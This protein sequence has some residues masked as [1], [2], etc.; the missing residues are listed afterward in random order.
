MEKAGV[1]VQLNTEATPELV[2]AENP[3]AVFLASGGKP[4]V[5]PL[6][7]IEGK[8]SYLPMMSSVVR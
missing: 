8:M 4:I 5:A 2:K 3:E 6:P 7:G 1:K